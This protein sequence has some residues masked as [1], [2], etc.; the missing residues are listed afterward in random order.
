MGLISRVSSRTYRSNV[1]LRPNLQN[2]QEVEEQRRDHQLQAQPGHEVRQV[3]PGLPRD[4][5]EAAKL[6]G[7][8][9]HP[10]RQHP[11][12][13]AL[14]DRVLRYDE[15]DRRPPTPVTTS[16]S[17]PL[18]VSTSESDACASPTPVTRTSSRWR[19]T[20]LLVT[21]MEP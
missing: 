11:G 4:P 1:Q 17:V 2:G 21:S 13:Q 14:R 20:K 3:R 7:Q 5:E 9:D 15:Q 10:G 19:T 18:A 8:A 12:P 16:S 6:Q